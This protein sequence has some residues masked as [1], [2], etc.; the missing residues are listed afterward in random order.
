[1]KFSKNRFYLS[2]LFVILLAVLYSRFDLDFLDFSSQNR[3][4][5]AQISKLN[6]VLRTVN[7]YY[8]D[9]LDWQQVTTGAIEGL[10]KKLDPHSVYFDP[11]KVEQNE[12]NFNGHY[13][14]IG[15]QF[16]VLDGLI[17]VI[18]VISGS[19]AQEV[20]L[21]AGDKITHINGNSARNISNA[22]VP[23]KLKGPKGS[24]VVV[25]IKR[26]GLKPFDVTIFRDEIP[27]YTVNTYFKP[28]SQTGYIWL[29]RFANTTNDEFESALRE[30]EE[31]GI[32]RL[33]IDLRG[34]GGGFLR[35]AVELVGKFVYGHK[36]VVYTKGRLSRYDETYFT[37]DFGRSRR[38]DY[39][40]VVL[41]DHGSASASEIVAG[42]LQDYDRA[43]IVGARS[44]GKGLVQNE[45][46]LNDG[47]RIRLTVSKYYT[48]S[49]RLIQRPYKG[50]PIEDYY[51]AG[52]RDSMDQVED[53]TEAKPVFYTNAGR[54]VYGGGGINPDV[55]VAYE[56]YSKS[57]EL[58]AKLHTK[59]IF[60]ETADRFVYAN[61]HWKESYPV[62]KQNF[63]VSRALLSSLVAV[64]KEKEIEVDLKELEKDKAYV[65]N[66]LK[67]EIV[68]NI[69]GASKFYQVLLEHDNQ[70]REALLS[71]AKTD[72]TLMVSTQK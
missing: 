44:F 60:F 58:T 57:A 19:P 39:P 20:G 37:D 59:R 2:V 35:Q 31:S 36:K 53:S 38:R 34:N 64:A 71:F 50:R 41:I 29:D 16:D 48:P 55:K 1:M 56:S 32:E 52:V 72:S 42:A 10:L 13:Q 46:E 26:N 66:R 65:K 24:E 4:K 51:M 23:K 61:P 68:R 70:F 47:S 22:D 9:T 3:L 28:D 33:I 8:V 21:Q 18:A 25:T 63:K 49:G 5:R 43:V 67:A 14:G 69:W 40:L 7:N 45:F 30:M 11:V 62:F 12:E 17:T 54:T 27:I 15:I 6:E